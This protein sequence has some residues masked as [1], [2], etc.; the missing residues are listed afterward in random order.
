MFLVP[1]KEDKGRIKS[2]YHVKNQSTEQ[3]SYEVMPPKNLEI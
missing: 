3:F 1:N 2:Q